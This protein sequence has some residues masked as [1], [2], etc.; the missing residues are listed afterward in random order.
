[1]KQQYFGSSGNFTQE[2]NIKVAIACIAILLVG[3]NTV[4]ATEAS[5]VA[6]R[7]SLRYIGCCS[8]N[9][10]DLEVVSQVVRIPNV[11]VRRRTALTA[12]L[13]GQH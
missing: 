9:A 11:M 6:F 2:Q 7:M 12:C 5:D 4:F 13:I 3:Y 10:G 8:A 1:M